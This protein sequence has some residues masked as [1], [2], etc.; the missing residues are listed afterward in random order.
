MREAV[1]LAGVIA[2]KGRQAPKEVK[3]LVTDGTKNVVDVINDAKTP[4]IKSIEELASDLVSANDKKHRVTLRSEKQQ[5]EIDLDG[6]THNDVPTPHT[7]VSDRNF[8]AP[9]E[10]QPAYNTSERKSTLRESTIQDVRM[11]R[12]YLERKKR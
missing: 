7:K 6:K 5:L 3:E 11:A 1:T 10:M 4:S 12:N 2:S 9:E 8:K